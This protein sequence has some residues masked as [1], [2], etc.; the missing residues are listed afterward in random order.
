MDNSILPDFVKDQIREYFQ[1]SCDEAGCLVTADWKVVPFENC[2][3]AGSRAALIE[4]RR[5]VDVMMMARLIEEGNL[6]AWAHS[7]PRFPCQP[8]G[9]DIC[10]HNVPCNMVIWSGLD[11]TF[12]ATTG[13]LLTF[14][15]STARIV[16]DGKEQK[17]TELRR[18]IKR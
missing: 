17:R 9:T 12:G 4:Q 1:S 16:V 11:D 10:R 2:A 8:S 6:F 14:F 13:R 5:D 15:R 3:S 7:H 18:E